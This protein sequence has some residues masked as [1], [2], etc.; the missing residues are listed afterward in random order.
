M[1]WKAASLIG[2]L[3]LDYNMSEDF[4]LVSSQSFT[5][6]KTSY[7]SDTN[8]LTKC[9]QVGKERGKTKILS[10]ICWFQ[11]LNTTNPPHISL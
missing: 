9:T 1:E 11:N 2:T 8:D 7:L 5:N 3:V 4:N 6:Y 10:Q